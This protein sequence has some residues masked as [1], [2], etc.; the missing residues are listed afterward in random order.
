MPSPICVSSF[1]CTWPCI[2]ALYHGLVLVLKRLFDM[3]KSKL[4]LNSN[5]G[6]KDW[7]SI[8]S[9]VFF[10]SMTVSLSQSWPDS[11]FSFSLFPYHD[12]APILFSSFQNCFSLII[13]FTFLPQLPY[14]KDGPISFSSFQWCFLITKMAHLFTPVSK[15]G[16]IL[17]LSFEKCHLITKL[18]WFVL[19]FSPPFPYNK[20]GPILFSTFHRCFFIIKLS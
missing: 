10:L 2:V 1:S 3:L 11:V 12:F 6:C 8:I 20:V 7:F 15:M 17:L 18:A 9:A 13:I 16:L 4:R 19:I 14:H 5:G